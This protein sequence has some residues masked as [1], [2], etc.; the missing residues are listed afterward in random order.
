MRVAFDACGYRPEEFTQ[1]LA[2]L[3]IDFEVNKSNVDLRLMEGVKAKLE[4]NKNGFKHVYN[5]L[6][7]IQAAV[8]SVAALMGED[9]A[10]YTSATRQQY[11]EICTALTTEK[12]N[13]ENSQ[14]Q[15]AL[16]SL[17]DM[18]LM[19]KSERGAYRIEDEQ[20]ATW[21]IENRPKRIT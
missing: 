1:V 19:W 17:R 14:I 13:V 10:P 16:E 15:Y 12:V 9:Y 8:L 7:P 5:A 3:M 20:L 11:E 18:S 2:S 21:L 6:P 4:S